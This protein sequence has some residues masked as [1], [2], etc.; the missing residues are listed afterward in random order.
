MMI[1]AQFRF[2][3]S[4]RQLSVLHPFTPPSPVQNKI[5]SISTSGTEDHRCQLIG[6]SLDCSLLIQLQHS[7]L[8]SSLDFLSG[9]LA[10]ETRIVSLL[11]HFVIVQR[12]TL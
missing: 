2:A 6:I 11:P 10:I 5:Y 3:G 9:I 4:L 7:F 12:K 1:L 8:P